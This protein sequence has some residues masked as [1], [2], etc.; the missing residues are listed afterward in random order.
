VLGVSVGVVIAAVVLFVMTRPSTLVLTG[1]VTTNDVIVSPQVGGQIGTLLVRE[2]D[3]V[4][5]NELLA[6]L[7]PTELEADRAFYAH[8][9]AQGAIE[10]AESEA[11]L[12][13]Q[14]Q[15]TAAQID[16][17]QAQLASALAQQSEAAANLADAT[18]TLGRYKALLV[19]GAIAQQDLDQVQTTYDVAQARA[20]AADESV[21]AQRA[22]LALARAEAEQIAVKRSALLAARQ[23][24]GA[25]TAQRAKADVRLSYT[26]LR[27]PIAG[28]VDVRAARAGETVAAGQPILTLINPDSLWVRADVEETYIDRVRLG[29]QL[30]VR[31]PSGDLRRG[32]VF[33][34]GIDADFATQR[35]VSR[36]KRDIK[37]FEIRLRVDNHDRRLA[38]GMTAYVLLPPPRRS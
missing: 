2:G 37:T 28:I 24:Q 21:A 38:V 1:I 4:T 35:D 20:H 22:A 13:Y 5:Q 29:D 27:A 25:A 11:T 19:G 23:A 15:Q 18:R 9:A 26:E 31:L 30:T 36:S 6:T 10:V 8:G 3:S 14:E 7:V 17:A 34:R 32:T 12:R 33:Y 16:Q